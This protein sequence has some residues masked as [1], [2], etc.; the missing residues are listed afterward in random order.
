MAAS[1]SNSALSFPARG[2]SSL[3]ESSVI[4]ATSGGKREVFS[5]WDLRFFSRS[6]DLD[7]H[8]LVDQK[9]RQ[10]VE[11]ERNGRTWW[12]QERERGW[13]EE[14]LK[15]ER[16]MGNL[17]IIFG[18]RWPH[19]FTNRNCSTWIRVTHPTSYPFPSRCTPNQC[20]KPPSPAQFVPP[21]SLVCMLKIYLCLLGTTSARPD[22]HLPDGDDSFAASFFQGYWSISISKCEGMPRH[23]RQL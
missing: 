20:N 16:R 6:S 3:V 10:R 21:L 9:R 13:E 19:I 15:P 8:V 14:P 18:G 22:L 23:L 11:Y 17:Y 7:Q 2:F 5:L 12:E 4:S 1:F